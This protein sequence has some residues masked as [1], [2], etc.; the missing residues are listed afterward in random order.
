MAAGRG[1]AQSAGDPI[2]CVKVCLHSLQYRYGTEST[3]LGSIIINQLIDFIQKESNSNKLDAVNV[4][5][6]G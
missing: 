3:Q 6:E 4:S 2:E 1:R 5:V